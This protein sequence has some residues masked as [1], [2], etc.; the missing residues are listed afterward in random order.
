MDAIGGGFQFMPIIADDA[1]RCRFRR[2]GQPCFSGARDRADQLAGR[3]RDA[4]R[5][6]RSAVQH[7]HARCGGEGTGASADTYAIVN[8]PGGFLSGGRGDE[9]A[10]R[11]SLPA[12]PM[13][14][15]RARA[16]ILT[17]EPKAA[18]GWLAAGGYGVPHA[19]QAP[20]EPASTARSTDAA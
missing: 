13:A 18:I 1:V 6:R 16:F 2:D 7:P 20:A 17:D 10:V 9:L 12:R 3:C 8:K 11:A 19:D 4:D 14:S 15:G 5:D